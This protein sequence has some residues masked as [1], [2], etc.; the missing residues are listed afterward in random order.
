MGRRAAA[1]PRGEGPGCKVPDDFG[2]DSLGGEGMGM[3]LRPL[4][5]HQAWC[6]ALFV[7]P[8]SCHAS[9]V[10]AS[11]TEG[12]KGHEVMNASSADYGS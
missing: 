4:N 7:S 8:G 6:R 2:K 1:L 3:C 10:L 12:L 11:S 9:L 5:V